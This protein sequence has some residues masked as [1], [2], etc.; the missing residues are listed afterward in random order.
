MGL[1]TT[2]NCWHGP[3]S[4]FN[5]FRYDLGRQIGIDL[6]DYAGYRGEGVKDLESIEHDLMILFNHSDC[7]G[8][9]SPRECLK[10]VNGLDNILDNLNTELKIE[11]LKFEDK[12]KQFRDGCKKAA[13]LG[14][15]VEFY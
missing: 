8:G 6:D 7:D 9:L 4:S 3:Y 5:S 15:N 12:I 2:H 11:T 1:D 14:E 13:M 10:I